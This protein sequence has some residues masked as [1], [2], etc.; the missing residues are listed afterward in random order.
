MQLSAISCFIIRSLGFLESLHGY[1]TTLN[2]LTLW[3]S[4]VAFDLSP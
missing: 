2:Q 3:V 4:I 1:T